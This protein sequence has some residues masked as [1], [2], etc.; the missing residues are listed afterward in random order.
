[1]NL[2][3][4][5]WRYAYPPY[6]L[7]ALAIAL[8]SADLYAASFAERVAMAKEIETQEAASDYF[9]KT[10]FPAIGPDMAGM[11]KY[12]LSLPDASK[13]RF[14]LVAN[15]AQDGGMT[16]VDFEPKSNNTG[17]C[18]AEAFATLVGPP[19]PLCDCGALPVVIEMKVNP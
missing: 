10:L 16:D 19:P 8:A 12:C 9:L 13:E 6:G 14:T 4:G 3:F 2:P 18:F 1:M 11:M 7:C 5:G 15:V 17:A